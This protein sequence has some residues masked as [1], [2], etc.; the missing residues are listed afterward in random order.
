MSAGHLHNNISTLHRTV[1]IIGSSVA[2][3]VGFITRCKMLREETTM[4]IDDGIAA[5]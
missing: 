4:R 3:L 1:V 2:N 5:L